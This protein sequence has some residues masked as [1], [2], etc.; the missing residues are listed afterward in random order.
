MVFFNL[1]TC[2]LHW[3]ISFNCCS[4]IYNRV[5]YANFL[6]LSFCFPLIAVLP[7]KLENEIAFST[8]FFSA[9]CKHGLFLLALFPVKLKVHK[10]SMHGE[11]FASCL[12]YRCFKGNSEE[13]PHRT[14]LISF[15]YCEEFI[16]CLGNWRA[17][18]RASGMPA[19]LCLSSGC[20]EQH[21]KAWQVR[22]WNCVY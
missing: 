6:Y 18:P 19:R 20:S 15:S 13:L 7:F 22:V 16:S 9:V 2:A 1:F 11:A 8:Y 3:T 17:A 5:F 4:K 12:S 10:H 21:S 14:K